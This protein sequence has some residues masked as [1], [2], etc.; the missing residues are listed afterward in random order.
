M[1]DRCINIKHPEF[2]D[3]H[4]AV[5]LE[6]P[7]T[8]IE[9]SSA[10]VMWQ[11]DTNTL[12]DFPSVEQI[13]DYISLKRDEYLKLVRAS[14]DLLARG[15][16]I[17]KTFTN[18]E[19]DNIVSS[20]LS[21]YYRNYYKKTPLN[22]STIVK[23]VNTFLFNNGTYKGIELNLRD[24]GLD[25][26][27]DELIERRTELQLKVINE[28]ENIV[29][30]RILSKD[31]IND[32]FL[33]FKNEDEESYKEDI[34]ES[35]TIEQNWEDGGFASINMRD[36]A[37]AELTFLLSTLPKYKN[38]KR[39]YDSK[40]NSE[41]VDFQSGWMYLTNLLT[42]SLDFN[43]MLTKL[44][45]IVFTSKPE[46]KPLYD[47]LISSKP[48]DINLSS[49]FF[50]LMNLTKNKKYIDLFV[51]KG[52]S[53]QIESDR[54]NATKVI[55][56][57]WDKKFNSIKDIND[58]PENNL[59]VLKELV[60]EETGELEITDVINKP[61][62]E[63]K[64][65][66]LIEYIK[67]L[68]SDNIFD[69]KDE[70]YTKVVNE[71]STIGIDLTKEMLDDD[72]GSNKTR[73]NYFIDNFTY[74]YK[75]AFE[76]GEYPYTNSFVNN[77]LA[78]LVSKY[79][80]VDVESVHSNINGDLE[81]S[82]IIPSQYSKYL[83]R[84]KSSSGKEIITEMMQ[85]PSYY[86]SV[87]GNILIEN[88]ED[89]EIVINGGIKE[90]KP[91]S[92]GISYTDMG[93]LELEKMKM[94]GFVY[95]DKKAKT[96]FNGSEND[97]TVN[98][99]KTNMV[100]VYTVV[101]SDGSTLP[102][103]RVPKIIG[104]SSEFPNTNIDLGN[105][106]KLYINSYANILVDILQQENN[107]IK[108]AIGF[109][110]RLGEEPSLEEFSIENYDYKYDKGKKDYKLGGGKQRFDFTFL[111]NEESYNKFIPTELG[112][113]FEDVNSFINND[114]YTVEQ[115][116]KLKQILY[117]WL[118]KKSNTQL[119]N[120]KD[121]GLVEGDFLYPT[122]IVGKNSNNFNSYEKLSLEYTFNNFIYGAETQKYFTGNVAYAGNNV[123][124]QKRAKSLV[125]PSMTPNIE[126]MNSSTYGLAV[127]REPVKVSEYLTNIKEGLL[128]VF[129]KTRTDVDRVNELVN[130]VAYAYEDMKVADG[131]GY[132]HYKEAINIFKGF[133]KYYQKYITALE[134][135]AEGKPTNVDVG[136]MLHM[137]KDNHVSLKYDNQ[138]KLTVKKYVKNA[139]LILF[140]SLVKDTPLQEL[141]NYMEKS[142]NYHVV[143]D[144]G[145]KQGAKD[146]T[147]IENKKGTYD[148]SKLDTVK[149]ETLSYE[150]WGIQFD[151]PEHHI[152]ADGKFGV[153]AKRFITVGLD[154]NFEFSDGTKAKNIKEELIKL[155]TENIQD[156][157]NSLKE[158]ISTDT[159][160]KELLDEQLKDLSINSIKLFELDVQGN[161][162]YPLFSNPDFCKRI[163]A[164]LNGLYK[165]NV[166]VQRM[167]G[168]SYKQ[169]SSF[170][171]INEK[172]FKTKGRDKNVKALSEL[173]TN[174]Q[175]KINWVKGEEGRLDFYTLTPE[176]DI[177]SA[178]C[179]LPYWSKQ[180][181]RGNNIIDINNIPKEL[182]EIIGFRIP[183][184]SKSSII[185]LEVV[186]FL[187][188]EAGSTIILPEEIVSLMG[189]DFDID[190]LFTMFPNFK[191]VQEGENI[192]YVKITDLKTKEGRDNRIQDI[193]RKIL[194]EPKLYNQTITPLGLDKLTKVKENIL[195]IT[196]DVEISDSVNLPYIQTQMSLNNLAGKDLT[197]V[198][199]NYTAN[200]SIAEQSKLRI[201]DSNYSVK[202]NNSTDSTNGS[203]E[204]KV[205]LDEYTNVNGDSIIEG[206]SEMLQSAV[207]NAKELI[208]NTINSNTY[209]APVYSLLL[210]TGTTLN[211]S[212]LFMNQSGIRKAYKKQRLN[213]GIA[214]KFE[215]VIEVVTQEYINKLSKSNQS[216][217]NDLLNSNIKSFNF[218]DNE[219]EE[220]IIISRY[221]S[222]GQED[223]KKFAKSIG[224]ERLEF[225]SWNIKDKNEL[226]QEYYL[227]QIKALKSFDSYLELGRQ[228]QKVLRNQKL[229]GY[230]GNSLADLEITQNMLADTTINLFSYNT[231]YLTTESLLKEVL[232]GNDSFSAIN[233][234]SNYIPFNTQAFKEAKNKIISL[235]GAENKLKTKKSGEKLLKTINYELLTALNSLK[236]SPLFQKKS[237]AEYLDSYLKNDSLYQD[238]IYLIKKYPELR[239]NKIF[240]TIKV[241]DKKQLLLKV[242]KLTD[243]GHKSMENA[244]RELLINP[245]IQ[246]PD[247]EDA[248]KIKVF[249]QNLIRYNYITNG[250]KPGFN[251]IFKFIPTDWYM[252]TIGFSKF[253]NDLQNSF[254]ESNL[255][256]DNLVEQVVKNLLSE[257][258]IFQTVSKERVKNINTDNVSGITSFES[259]ISYP[260]YIKYFN[261]K[262]IINLQL[263]SKTAIDNGYRYTYIP[264]KSLSVK[265]KSSQ[266]LSYRM[267]YGDDN[268]KLVKQ[269]TDDEIM[270][271][272]E[273]KEFMSKELLTNPDLM[274]FDILDYYKK[275]K[276]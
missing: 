117:F 2:I 7:I 256:S 254:K 199:A 53:R 175:S 66:S 257:N 135:L 206:I 69:K 50:V 21:F 137:V 170:G 112:I 232:I 173:D 26:Q 215:N 153:Q 56:D 172:N 76:N 12:E 240:K 73:F 133:G 188:K 125:S 51:K 84:Y 161:F 23:S 154:D 265:G 260:E 235:I 109:S 24:K 10:V 114:T 270:N 36:K 1:A 59:I 138:R 162:K 210:E 196:G 3:F 87:L 231:E 40:G 80:E 88:P 242:G 207:D 151:V 220:S 121:L 264:I 194:I 156:S 140:P 168:G 267:Y 158:K 102:C 237:P 150:D 190:T 108:E 248:R 75:N 274:V 143:Y 96:T 34:D 155:Q 245:E 271:T 90:D 57:S 131:L 14:S 149:G 110:S 43:D 71:L 268:T 62:F 186:G 255:I 195:N 115:K 176:G 241:N 120:W 97:T 182:R 46:Y 98:F 273:F 160:L 211:T 136:L 276:V 247:S 89:V 99:L 22:V 100:R 147:S 126:S 214:G 13:L 177:K 132:L 41:Y 101:P 72:I 181:V 61:F 77:Y 83:N 259:T 116:E 159:S 4:N 48:T 31:S 47:V 229:D 201:N 42:D 55:V 165:S 253:N 38:G 224:F 93:A 233:F 198:W 243:K 275:C 6:S 238:Y 239:N 252:D 32:N 60:N 203:Y 39:I 78:P 45:D 223:L 105:F 29:N 184:A 179:L 18:S 218:N 202:F 192:N 219:L 85:D 74:I 15:G 212:S 130:D 209:T 244:F 86:N 234:I 189:S 145:I 269:L 9:L 178:K 128:N 263:D 249:A 81:Q 230:D 208:H 146:V 33:L 129:G 191:V 68:R 216:Y 5:N 28:V 258:G 104:V 226:T 272:P 228:R 157:W 180:F 79:V 217:I 134:D 148:F 27:A 107:R 205:R 266:D 37:S 236:E 213:S 35:K 163:E 25:K 111:N 94:D 127:I 30:K 54:V 65:N 70:V 142:G 185:S 141:Y 261:G 250:F 174:T 119:Q 169:A 20:A 49:H 113:S 67:N 193:F 262:K 251:N 106:K 44:S 166:V 11:D 17:Y 118:L 167:N 152:D 204:G 63:K 222:S 144:S 122:N 164:V 183:T 8:N 171:F 52:I 16:R 64:Y 197:A 82:F 92:E 124:Y 187:P 58:N 225:N 246:T 123:N 221:L 139:K 19:E 200:R 95:S 91:G 103:L 227:F